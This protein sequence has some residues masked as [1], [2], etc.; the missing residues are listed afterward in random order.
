VRRDLGGVLRAL[1]APTLALLVVGAF[2]PGRLELAVR[3]YALVVC[4]VAL[5]LALRALRRSYPPV[6]PLR[7]PAVRDS[8]SRSAPPSLAR[9]EHDAALGVAG[10][11]DLHFRLVPRIRAIAGGLLA[12]RRR[13]N[14]DAQPDAARDILGLGTWELVREDRPAPDDRRARGLPTS[15]LRRVVESLEEI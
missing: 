13:L 11:L 7:P 14:L 8:G 12:S 15:D 4:A 9:I 5:G 6:R 10:G 3:I 2:A 1:I